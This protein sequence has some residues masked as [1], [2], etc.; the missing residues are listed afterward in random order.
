MLGLGIALTALTPTVAAAKPPTLGDT[1]QIELQKNGKVDRQG[2]ATVGFRYRCAPS[3][4]LKFISAEADISQLFPGGGGTGGRYAAILPDR[5]GL[6]CTGRWSS[7]TLQ[8]DPTG[9]GPPFRRGPAQVSVELLF[10]DF[11]AGVQ[12]YG[13]EQATVRLTGPE[14]ERGRDDG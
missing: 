7:G 8:L 14:R 9:L 10:A 12:R 2:T 1:V 3:P 6:R 4:D 11:T 13:V 5:G